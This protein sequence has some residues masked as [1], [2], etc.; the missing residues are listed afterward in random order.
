[1]KGFQTTLVWRGGP[2]TRGKQVL[3]MG[4]EEGFHWIIDYQ[5][6]RR[7]R[8][9]FCQRAIL[10]A[11][12]ANTRIMFFVVWAVVRKNPFELSGAGQ[13]SLGPEPRAVW[14]GPSP[15]A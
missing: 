14:A 9:G 12:K 5:G 3:D 7:P 8:E 1:M 15:G 4:F 11:P 6:L 13:G 10:H 2:G